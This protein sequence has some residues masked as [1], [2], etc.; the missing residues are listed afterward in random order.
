MDRLRVALVGAGFMGRMHANVYKTLPNAELVA[1]V[2]SRPDMA[3]AIVGKTGISAFGDLSEAIA[4]T[5][6]DVVDICL[7]THL[8]KPFVIEAAKAGKHVVCEKPMALSLNEADEMVE[9]CE[10]AGVYFMVA[11]CIRF[12]PEY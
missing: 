8:H 1:V 4:S 5:R 9:A 11:H 7:P 3:A 2:D 12:W 6:P 10:R